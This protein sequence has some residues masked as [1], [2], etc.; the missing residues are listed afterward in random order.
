ML[1]FLSKCSLLLVSSCS[2]SLS[3]LLS[4]RSPPSASLPS[5]PLRSDHVAATRQ[6]QVVHSKLDGWQRECEVTL[7]AT[8]DGSQPTARH[9]EHKGPSPLVFSIAKSLRVSA[10]AVSTD[11]RASPT[12]HAD[13]K[14]HAQ[15]GVGMLLYKVVGHGSDIQVKEILEG[16]SV[17]QHNVIQIGD[18][19]ASIA[20]TELHNTSMELPDIT[21]LIVGQAHSTIRFKI[22]RPDID[23]TGDGYNASE[24][25]VNIERKAADKKAPRNAPVPVTSLEGYKRVLLEE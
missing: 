3:S 23:T 6:V 14:C 2:S 13:F 24:F 10:V 22:V 8:T 16:G 12:V 1:L 19:V 18:C 17:W 20:G 7:Y 11:A 5:F 25:F 4:S 15:A 9:F 21:R